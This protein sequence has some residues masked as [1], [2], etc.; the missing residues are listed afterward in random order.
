MSN[1][2]KLYDFC[3]ICN[4]ENI[5]EVFKLKSTPPGDFFLPKEKLEESV[6]KYPLILALCEQ[7]GYLHLPYILDPKISYQNYLYETGISV[8]LRDNYK[9]YASNLIQFADLD[10]ADLVVDIGSND[11]SMLEA[12]K[13]FGMSVVGV[14]PSKKHSDLANEE[15]LITINSFFNREASQEIIKKFGKPLMITSNNTFANIENVIQFTENVMN[16]LHQDGVFI[17]QT[18]YHPEQMKINMFDYIYHEHFSYF[19]VQVLRDLL[20]R[21]GLELIHAEKHNIKGGSIRV[22][23]Q[24]K[25]A[26]RKTE[27]SVNKIIAEE[28][29]N[30]IHNSETYL[31]FSKNISYHKEVLLTFLKDIHKQN[32]R[33][34][35]YGASHSTTTLL[36]HF[37]ISKFIERIVDDNPIKH[38]LYSPGDHKKVYP[39][40]SLNEDK[41]DYILILAWQHQ[42]SIIERC[43]GFI[44]RGIKLIIPLPE[45]KII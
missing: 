28:R 35:G 30:N 37:E 8:G 36:H 18:G 33:I 41:P 32:K 20:D 23:A 26:G 22:I 3:R 44:D 29:I 1:P 39:T 4:S 13:S 45:F 27:K 25:G 19:S 12:F 5:K 10:K 16:L 15:S 14:E 21:C 43:Q 38:N 31:E 9:S 7:C 40:S 34:V 11:G 42:E 6:E 24:H 2:I 17:I